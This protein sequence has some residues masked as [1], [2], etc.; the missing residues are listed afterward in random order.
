MGGRLNFTLEQSTEFD[1]ASIPEADA[2]D[3]D[4]PLESMHEDDEAEIEIAD[5]VTDESRQAD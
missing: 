3:L 1:L 4:E 2:D 5:D